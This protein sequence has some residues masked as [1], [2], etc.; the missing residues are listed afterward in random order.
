MASKAFILAAGFGTRLRPITD[1]RPKPMA[2]VN[3]KCL[4]D[5]T[6][7]H[8]KKADINDLVVNTHYLADVLHSHLEKRTDVNISIS[9][10]KTILDTGGGIKKALPLFDDEDFFVLSGDGLWS[11]KEEQSAIRKLSN[12][13]DPEKMDILMLLQPVDQMKVTKGVGDY[14]LDE[15]NRATRSLDQNGAFM[16]TSIR[17][18]KSSIFKDT[19]NTPFSYLK[20]LD[21]AQKTRRLFGLVHTGDWHH[22]ST[23]QDLEAIEDTYRYKK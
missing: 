17:I 14:D 9:N 12:M 18:N 10:E 20:L 11:D 15:H 19:P 6:I 5:Y 2:Q 3:G 21:R 23:P 4:I 7:D 13:W 1:S 16:F 8:L 22:I